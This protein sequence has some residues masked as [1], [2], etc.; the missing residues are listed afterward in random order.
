MLDRARYELMKTRYGQ[1]GS[2]AVWHPA[3]ATPKSNTEN[4]DW[5]RDP[6]LLNII[7]T[8]YVF[9][10]LNWS[11]THGDVTKGGTIPWANFH[12]GYAMQND[13]KLRFALCGT[14]FWG[15]YITD[16]IKLYAEVNSKKVRPYLNSHPGLEAKNIASFEEEIGMLGWQKPV[17][18]ALGTE[19]G[20]ILKRN[21]ANRY[22]I[23]TVM[24]YSNY[25]SKEAYRES[26]LSDLNGI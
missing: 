16:V 24:H 14:K 12:S 10:G 13:F 5:V 26:V 23:K 1:Y 4:M 9:V 19:A 22:T 7:N 11:S 15:S 18:I 21:L 6:N 25:I 3:G 8:G 2:W 20:S 17:L